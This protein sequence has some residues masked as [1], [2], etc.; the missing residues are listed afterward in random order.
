MPNAPTHDLITIVTAIGLDAAYCRFAPHPD[1]MLAA[2][3][4]GSYLFAGYACAGDLD[5]DSREYHR[6][7]LLRF[8]W[9]PYRVL[10]PHR[11]WISHGLLLGGA[12]RAG[13]LALATTLLFWFVLWI[14]SAAGLHM[15]TVGV[16]AN[17]W[18]TLIAWAR[19]HPEPVAAVL[20]G[21][22]LA[23]TAHSVAD[24]VYSGF[25]RRLRP[26]R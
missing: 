19:L 5:L 17:G 2:L 21:F 20:S 15:D 10:V 22:V 13:Y 26:F 23:G 8:I 9:W 3:F 14:L 1:P 6:W 25:K 7:G 11:S 12:I 24:I 18:H 16:T 4:T